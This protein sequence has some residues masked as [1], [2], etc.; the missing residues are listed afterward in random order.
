[1]GKQKYFYCS[2]CDKK[3]QRPV[4][5]SCTEVVTNDTDLSDLDTSTSS[6]PVSTVA[7]NNSPSTSTQDVNLLLLQEMKNMSAK[8]NL[9]EKRLATTEKQLQTSIPSK[10]QSDKGKGKKIKKKVPPVS[11]PLTSDDDSSDADSVVPSKKFIK[12]DPSIQEQV[13]TRLEEL[14]KLNE[15]DCQGKFKSQRSVNDDV[16]VKF[17]IPWPQHQ[18]LSGST[19]SRPSY[20]QLNVYQWVS[21]F[22][23]IAQDEPDID[24]KNKML[25]YLADLMEDAQDFSWASAKAAHAVALCRMEDGKLTWQDTQGLDRVRR[26]HAQKNIGSVNSNSGV[27]SNKFG[28]NR[29]LGFIC[30]FFQIGT[31]SHSKDHISAGRKYRHVCSHCQG[32]HPAKECKNNE[33]KSKNE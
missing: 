29:D 27:A 32:S 22:A 6:L 21:G 12:E 11:Q 16:T 3:H 8:M 33:K 14:K 18:V 17:K 13:K 31:C 2:K 4:G 1:M 23:R 7:A 28:K 9:M 19:R 20:D 10:E 26:A 24:I 30:K 25:D 5:K 15:K